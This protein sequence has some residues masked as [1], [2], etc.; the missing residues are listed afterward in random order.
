MMTWLPPL[1]KALKH[2]PPLLPAAGKWVNERQ[3]ESK[4]TMCP[5]LLPE[6]P[7]ETT[8]VSRIQAFI[9]TEMEKTLGSKYL[10][11]GNPC[12]SLLHFY[13]SHERLWIRINITA[14]S[15]H[16]SI[17]SNW[18][19]LAVLAKHC[20]K[21]INLHFFLPPR[22]SVGFIVLQFK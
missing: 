21:H 14:G 1:S 6:V 16:S 18:L 12:N 10:A 19:V 8:A 5:R 22:F 17:E 4:I 13:A 2:P 3:S 11:S 9:Q 20:C 7:A 15:L